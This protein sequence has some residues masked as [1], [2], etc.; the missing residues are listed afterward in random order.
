[1]AE[2]IVGGAFLS[3]FVNVVFDRLLSPE[4]ARLIRG[5]KLDHKLVERLKTVLRAVEAVL[6][7]AERK[8]IND[9]AVKKWLHEL[10][11][12][13]YVADD[14]L[15]GLSTEAATHKAHKKVSNFFSRFLNP[16]DRKMVSEMEDITIRDKDKEN[17]KKLLLDESS[18]E[19]VCVIPIVG[20]GGVGK[21]TL[22][23]WL[24]ND[25]DLKEEFDLKAWVCVSEESNVVNI[26]KC[27]TA[28]VNRAACDAEDL[29][30]LQ[31]NLEEK[32]SGKR[33][34]VV[35]DDVWNIDQHGWNNFKK[36]FQNGIKGSKILV[37]TRLEKVASIVQT[38]PP[39]PLHE[40]SDQ[41]CW[42]VFAKHACFP[43]CGGDSNL[44]RI[45]KDIVR[46]CQGLPLA[47]ET[48]GSLLQTK[49][50]T[51]DWNTI[52]TSELWEIPMEDNKIIP[53]LKISYYHLPPHLK[54]CF[55]YFS[56]FPKDYQFSK[57]ELIP[58][59]MAEDL[60]R[61]PKKGETLE[62]VG[63]ECFDDLTSRSFLKK[64]ISR[65]HDVYFVMHDLMHD[66]AISVARDFYCWSEELGMFDKSKTLTRHLSYGRLTHPISKNVD[67]IDELKSLRTFLQVHFSPPSFGFGS[68]I[69]I[70]LSKFKY[71]RVLSF[72]KCEELQELPDRIESLSKLYNLQTLKMS[73]CH[74]LTM[75]PSG[76]Q[77]LVNLRS[78]DISGT[79]VKEMP[80]GMSKLKHLQFLSNFVV[81]KHK[82]NGIKELGELSDL[83]FLGVMKLENFTNS[84]EA[85]EA[86]IKDKTHLK[87][88]T[89]DWSQDRNMNTSAHIE[90]IFDKLQPHKGL[91]ALQIPGY[92]GLHQGLTDLTIGGSNLFLREGLLPQ[93]PSLSTLQ[94]LKFE[95]METLD[96]NSL[97]HLTSL[98]VLRIGYC[99]KLKNMVGKRLPPSLVKLDIYGSPLL[100]E[101]CK[102]KH[103]QI[104][105]RISHIS[106]IQVD[107]KWISQESLDGRVIYLLIDSQEMS[108]WFANHATVKALFRTHVQRHFKVNAF[109]W[110]S[111]SGCTHF[112]VRTNDIP[113]PKALT[114]RMLRF[115]QT[116]FF[117]INFSI[118]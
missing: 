108:S 44:E 1:M 18:E 83:E 60:L 19:N 107:W 24:Y 93:L 14:L 98:E 81:G 110:L 104:W 114:Q 111:S 82:K 55:A 20:M 15:D 54:R 28:A 103:P 105:K 23:Q 91:E 4:V 64:L 29:N 25:E 5:K 59:W 22:V 68:V 89:L 34:L 66:L 95:T 33:F 16:R 77:N 10:R 8:Q 21:N 112:E 71:L 57:D 41:Y 116:N 69:L 52:L 79:K 75:L 58:L 50:D 6:N 97:L 45:G 92:R 39:Y 12:A 106:G 40:L 96:C 36:P 115:H 118:W 13:V 47:A 86:R 109:F 9:D 27:V 61:S 87:S 17:M 37:T 63:S 35:L 102:K 38:V 32:L 80:R 31:L 42:S 90:E 46:R 30:L 11:D 73:F 76:M 51:G 53:A 88:L 26:T 100:E 113:V 94:L 78:L 7:D 3:G 67:A 43:E 49:H 99:P 62:K 101:R 72:Y 74:L 56:L 70:I 117:Y 48:L 84:S 85:E 2:A 65:T